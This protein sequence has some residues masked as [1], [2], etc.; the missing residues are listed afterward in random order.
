MDHEMATVEVS[1][2]APRRKKSE[3]PQDKGNWIYYVY[4][5]PGILLFLA[6]FG[7][8]WFY[9]S[10]LSFTKWDGIGDPKWIGL[11]NYKWL[12]QDHTFWVS[13]LH[14]AEFI[15][16]MAIIPT[17][18]G[19]LLG[20]LIFDF[21]AARF[22]AP[23]STFLRAALFVPQIIP[24]TVSGVLWGWLYS[25]NNG[26][27]N[28]ILQN[29]HLGSLAQDWLGNE[30]LAIWS[31]SIMLVWIQIGYTIV[32]FVSGMSR[33]DPSLHEAAQLD[34]ATWSQRFRII[35]IPTLMPEISVVTL[36]TTVAALKVFGPVYTMTQGGP[37]DATQVPSFFSFF[38]FFTTLKIGYG[39]A[40]AT[41][42]SV[43]LIILSMLLLKLQNRVGGNQ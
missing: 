24:I 14:S 34:G 12:M 35:T 40:V 11:D 23:V 19:L 8:S 3:N 43:L 10:Y 37:G 1:T 26:V 22:G 5:A 13:F 25:P 27:V 15:L 9:N 29:L 36:T 28:T 30:K 42:L 33:I 41:I 31:V 21:V 38:H 6:L 17:I 32:I 18:L 16:A 20:A 39:A 2:K 7:G 4:A